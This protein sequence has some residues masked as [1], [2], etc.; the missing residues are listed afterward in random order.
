[1]KTPLVIVSVALVLAAVEHA[2]ADPETAPDTQIGLGQQHRP[3]V[4]TPPAGDALRRGKRVKDDGRPH[5]DPAHEGEAIHR[6]FFC[7]SISLLSAKR[8]GPDRPTRSREEQVV[9]PGRGDQKG[10]DTNDL[11][12]GDK[13][14]V[15]MRL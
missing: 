11:D 7:I 4:G 15:L 9:N 5:P 3:V 10:C 1:M 6:C 14:L 12:A 8:A 2:K 13:I